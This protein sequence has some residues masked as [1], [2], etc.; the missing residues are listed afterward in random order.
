MSEFQEYPRFNQFF[1]AIELVY[2][3]SPTLLPQA[4]LVLVSERI[5]VVSWR[6]ILVPG[7]WQVC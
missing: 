5:S 1:A 6:L 4:G 7:D 2:I 3:S